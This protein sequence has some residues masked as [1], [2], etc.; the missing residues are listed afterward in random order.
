M[1]P[2]IDDED[3]AVRRIGEKWQAKVADEQNVNGFSVSK[4]TF[5]EDRRNLSVG[6]KEYFVK[7]M[8]DYQNFCSPSSSAGLVSL[9]SNNQRH[10]YREEAFDDYVTTYTLWKL[11]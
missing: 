8:S 10:F 9:T 5:A 6:W 7:L 1:G 11:G 3:P 4:S 2:C